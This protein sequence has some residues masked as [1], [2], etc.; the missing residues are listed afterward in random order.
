MR[1]KPYQLLIPLLLAAMCVLHAEEKPE[2]WVKQLADEN[3]QVRE[4][5][6]LKLW[7]LGE[8]ALPALASAISSSDPEQAIRASD[9]MRKIQLHIT[10]DTDPSV[11]TLV[12][13]YVDA[14]PGEKVELIGKMRVKRAWRQML[15]LFATETHP[16]VRKR[17]ERLMGAVALQA[18]REQ[19]RLGNEAEAREYLEL[20]PANEEGLRALAEFH[21]SHGTLDA[22]L[23]RAQELKG[24]KGAAWRLALYS[25]AGNLT[26]ARDEAVAVGDPVRAAILS[27]LAGDPLPALRLGLKKEEDKPLGAAYAQVAIKRWQNEKIRP[28]DLDFM[29][30]ALAERDLSENN[31]VLSAL[32]LLGEV[33]M[34]EQALVKSQPLAAF[35]HFDALERIPE[36]LQALGL[37]PENPDYKAWV[38]KHLEKAL[39]LDIEDQHAVS[40]DE[41]EVWALANFME[42]RG[43]Y[44]QAVEAFGGPLDALSLNN[45]NRFREVLAKLFTPLGA[46]R[47]ARELALRWAGE[48]DDRWDDLVVAAFGDDEQVKVW[49]AWLGEIEPKSKRSERLDAMLSLFNICQFPE[50]F[51]EKWLSVLWKAVDA[52]PPVEAQG[53]VMRIYEMATQSDAGD[54]ATAMQA[55]EKLAPEAR[56]KVFF[57]QQL[58]QLSAVDRWN[59]AVALLLKQM[60]VMKA[61]G[62]EP[63][64]DLHAYVAAALRMAGR[65]KEAAEYDGWVNKLSLGNAATAMRIGN[66]Y[67]YGRDY[68]RAAEWWRRSVI[69]S[70]SQSEDFTNALKF[71]TD[72]LLETQQWHETAALSE[73]LAFQY[74]GSDY[75]YASHLP[76]MRFRL[77]AD[78][79]RALAGLA[80]NRERSLALLTECHQ[81]YASDGSLADFFFPALRQVG[82]IKQHDAWFRESWSRFETVIRRFPDADNVRNTA[83]WFASRAMRELDA[84]EQHSRRAIELKPRQSA[85]LDTMA[86]IQF[87]KGKRAK[88]LEWSNRAINFTPEDTLLRRQHERFRSAP[89]PK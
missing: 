63:G 35:V 54:V 51:R 6:S 30:R 1:M 50:D 3:F 57:G 5:A 76:L 86:E 28:A 49:W 70:G 73:L 33:E 64:A 16:E 12:E 60:D 72:Q 21:R 88:A 36:A 81:K 82:L 26:A 18:S 22:E 17:L 13:S 75:M 84:A 87:A 62:Q 34:A 80:K 29:R 25:A 24:P 27:A 38:E 42:R 19:M 59:D 67:A 23:K 66:G 10:P 7:K 68:Q 77:Q 71:Y 14:N 65:E 31:G 15:K 58:Y 2:E 9:I 69:Q 85:Y 56:D 44:E 78:T 47:V 20:G 46:P 4:S 11:I 53:F 37:D 48:D 89:L 8:A 39:E 52:A 45:P 32:F 43:L 41:S 74:V 83:A 55:W 79:A 61:A 40:D